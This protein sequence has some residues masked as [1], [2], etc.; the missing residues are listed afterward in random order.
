MERRD[1]Q[2]IVLVYFALCL[3]VLLAA[4]SFSVDLGAWYVRSQQIQRAADAAALAGVVWMPDNFAKAQQVALSTARANGFVNGVNGI[5]VTVTPD[6]VY[7][8]R[9]DV[10]IT[11]PKVPQAFSKAFVN[12]VTERR[13]AVGEY[14]LPVPLGSPENSLGTGNLTC[15]SHG[16]CITTANFWLSVKG[17]CAGKETGDRYSAYY[18]GNEANTSGSSNLVPPTCPVNPTSSDP[19][20]AAF[21]NPEYRS[22]GYAYDFV[23]PGSSS[24]PLVSGGDVTLEIYDPGFDL[25]DEGNNAPFDQ[26]NANGATPVYL[27]TFWTLDG[28]GA[29]S[30][31]THVNDPLLA[32]GEWRGD[33]TVDTT[34]HNRWC[35]LYTVLAGS[36][37][38]EYQLNISSQSSEAN[39]AAGNQFALPRPQG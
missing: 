24:N 20:G 30:P 3:V 23:V 17:F 33:T 13:M 35:A 38:G 21:D 4:A 1:E 39:D 25:A 32:S 2:G 8:H 16:T 26:S 7:S 6:P 19:A 22:D 15:G 37:A 11:D 36:T 14:D 9:L 31:L 5:T 34:C 10:T 27:N 28:V 18:D 12:N 29:G